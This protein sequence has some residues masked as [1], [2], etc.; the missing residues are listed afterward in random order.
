MFVDIILSRTVLQL[1][2]AL[3]FCACGQFLSVTVIAGD[4]FIF[5]VGAA[6]QEERKK[7]SV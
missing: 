4:L 1:T 3:C 7:E 6:G 2:V 5:T